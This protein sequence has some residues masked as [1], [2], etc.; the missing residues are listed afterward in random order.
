M[1]DFSGFCHHVF[2]DQFTYSYVSW[3]DSTQHFP[4]NLLLF[5]IDH[6]QKMNDPCHSYFHQTSERLL[7]E[8]GLKLTTPWNILP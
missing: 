7:A 4:S 8:L 3:P 5:H 2:K 1:K 6:G